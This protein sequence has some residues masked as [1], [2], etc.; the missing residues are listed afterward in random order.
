M[1]AIA[2]VGESEGLARLFNEFV[3]RVS[4]RRGSGAR[5][6]GR[7]RAL[8]VPHR[9]EGR[10]VVERETDA[11][12]LVAMDGGYEPYAHRNAHRNEHV[13]IRRRHRA[14]I[15]GRGSVARTRRPTLSSITSS[16]T[17]IAP[18]P[19]ARKSVS[20]HAIAAM[21]EI[22]SIHASS[23][24]R[25][26]SRR[27]DTT[28]SMASASVKP[29]TSDIERALRYVNAFVPWGASAVGGAIMLAAMVRAA[30]GSI[31]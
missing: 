28:D 26:G 11:A 5:R 19:M 17:T 6:L 24:A 29:T 30:N 16:R 12:D 15:V 31:G 1:D 2:R 14:E 21:L 23:G 25:C 3:V 22:V 4:S 10:G 27:C 9:N 13:V 20:S 7:W 18:A 8:G